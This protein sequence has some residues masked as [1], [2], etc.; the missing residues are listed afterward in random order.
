MRPFG[1]EGRMARPHNLL[2]AM[3]PQTEW[4]ACTAKGFMAGT[5]AARAEERSDDW[6]TAARQN[7]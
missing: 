2:K 1:K 4:S 5:K 6:G 3:Y 7:Q